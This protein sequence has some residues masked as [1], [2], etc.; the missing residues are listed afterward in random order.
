MDRQYTEQDLQ[1]AIQDVISGK[2]QAESAKRWAVPRSTLS[3]RL[4]GGTSREEAFQPLQR[5][6]SVLEERLCGWMI[7]E[8]TVGHALTHCQIRE[9]AGRMARNNGDEEPI[10]KNWVEGFMQ[11]NPEAKRIL[12][13]KRTG[14]KRKSD[15]ASIDIPSPSAKTVFNG[16]VAPLGKNWIQGFIRRNPEIKSILSR[17]K[18]DPKRKS[19][20][21]STSTDVP[22]PSAKRVRKR[23]M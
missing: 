9:V 5:L 16:D 14:L 1:N 17:R 3:K 12:S 7:I 2:S 15:V 18:T 19:N 20:G 6:S 10:G 21:A 13:G 4:Q 23:T 8:D 22:S 11:R